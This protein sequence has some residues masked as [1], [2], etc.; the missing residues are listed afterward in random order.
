VWRSYR[1][2]WQAEYQTEPSTQQS[3]WGG[4]PGKPSEVAETDS[5]N[6]RITGICSLRMY[7]VC[8]CMLEGNGQVLNTGHNPPR[9]PCGTVSKTLATLLP[10]SIYYRFWRGVDT[11]AGLRG[12]WGHVTR[13]IRNGWLGGGRMDTL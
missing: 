4:C 7:I 8:Q 5:T 11:V 6:A 1:R 10:Q 12:L 3:R 13:S 9:A 2:Q